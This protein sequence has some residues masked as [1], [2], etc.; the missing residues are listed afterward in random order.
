MRDER[1][2]ERSDDAPCEGERSETSSEY[3]TVI[4]SKVGRST[5]GTF[6]GQGPTAKKGGDL[7]R[8]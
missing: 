4:L 7:A 3:S 5:R 6:A 8:I 2:K 1:R